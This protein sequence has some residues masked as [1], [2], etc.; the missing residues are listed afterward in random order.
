MLQLSEPQKVS[1]Q[2]F[3]RSKL[4]SPKSIRAFFSIDEEYHILLGKINSSFAKNKEELIF[5]LQ[6]KMFHWKKT[7]SIEAILIKYLLPTMSKIIVCCD[8]KPAMNVA[9]KIVSP[10]LNKIFKK[11]ASYKVHSGLTKTQIR[12]SLQS[13]MKADNT[14]K[15]LY[16]VD[17]TEQGLHKL[18]SSVVILMLNKK[19]ASQFYQ[20][21]SRWV[22]TTLIEQP[23]LFDF[24][25]NFTNDSLCLFQK[26]YESRLQ[27]DQSLIG[28]GASSKNGLRQPP[29]IEF[30]D[31]TLNIQS[32]FAD[33]ERKFDSWKRYYLLAT[34]YYKTNGHLFIFDQHSPLNTWLWRQRVAYKRNNLD[35]RK[36]ACLN[37][38][39]MDWVGLERKWVKWYIAVK[40]YRE[41]YGRTPEDSDNRG[42]YRW[43]QLQRRLQRKGELLDEQEKLLEFAL[44]YEPKYTQR[45]LRSVQILVDHKRE[46]GQIELSSKN[47][48]YKQIIYIRQ[49]LYRNKLP[50]EMLATLKTNKI[51]LSK[52]TSWMAS[53]KSLKKFVAHF[54]KVPTWKDNKALS[55]WVSQQRYYIRKGLLREEKVRL[56]AKVLTTLKTEEIVLPKSTSWEASFKSLKQFVTR[57]RKLPTTED[58]IR[59]A[60][61]IY[62]Q[63]YCQ[64]KGLLR[65]EK[66]WLL[67]GQGVI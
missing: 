33:I 61:W 13:F 19:P 9:D 1:I 12:N 48:L 66:V 6:S 23:I 7:G 63:R 34:E 21:L 52:Y 18:K 64:K 2:V 35:T 10:I 37:L 43:L 17:M 55:T 51:H 26:E 56:L 60:R 53:Y 40:E 16:C 30:I 4:L 28:V 58:D 47:P 67:K 45:L 57:F 59:L 14:A 31:E 44:P 62:K 38:I 5:E 22:S 8:D 41:T 3:N 25:N 39:G 27:G 42:V 50:A 11:V 32:A 54:Q 65:E 20:E 29:A 49:A 24:A 36:V 46:Y 15:V